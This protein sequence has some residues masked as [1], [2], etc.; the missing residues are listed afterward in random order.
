MMLP[1]SV[2]RILIPI[3]AF[4]LPCSA[5]SPNSAVN[6]APDSILAVR[7]F[8]SNEYSLGKPIQVTLTIQS[9]SDQD[10]N[11]TIAENL[12]PK[13]TASQ[14]NHGGL[15][16][17]ETL[18]W[19]LS[20]KIGSLVLSY[21]VQPPA[22]TTDAA[23]FH[24]FCGGVPITGSQFLSPTILKIQTQPNG[25]W[26]YWTTADGLRETCGLCQ[27]GHDGKIWIRHGSVN[28]ISCLD[29][30]AVSKIPSPGIWRTLF[31]SQ[32][33]QLWSFDS[34]GLKLF[35]EGKWIA[36]PLDG[37][38]STQVKILSVEKDRV[39]LC[40]PDRLAEFDAI[41]NQ[42]YTIR[43]AAE[44]KLLR[45]ANIFTAK[46]G[47][48]LIAGRQGMARW[49]LKNRRSSLEASWTDY[50]FPPEYE[51]SN[52][53]FLVE[54]ENG[55]IYGSA[56]SAHFNKRVL[57]QFD[58]TAWRIKFVADR[59]IFAGWPGR[60]NG[61]WLWKSDEYYPFLDYLTFQPNEIHETNIQLPSLTSIQLPILE[62]GSP[63]T[64][65]S[66]HSF[67][68]S[69]SPGIARFALAA[70][71]TPETIANL[72]E[73]I[74]A[75][76]VDAQGRLWFTT[77]N[78]LLRLQNQE[79]KIYPLPDGFSAYQWEP[80]GVAYLKNGQ[81]AIRNTNS[82]LLLFDPET[83][84]FRVVN[85][86]QGK[87]ISLIFPRKDGSI[88]IQAEDKTST[89]Q[90]FVYSLEIY[91]GDSFRPFAD[92][93]DRWNL[94]QLRYIYE[95]QD[96]AI[97]LGGMAD[98]KIGVY[99]NGTYKTMGG[100]Y[101]GDSVMCIFPY[102]E[103]KLWFSDRNGIYEYDGEKWSVIR[104]GLDGVPSMIRSRDGSIWI[105]TWNG[106]YRYEHNSWIQNSELE[107]LSSFCIFKV[108]EDSQGRLWAATSRGLNLYHPEA[109]PDPP[110]VLIDP[111]V[112]ADEIA[113]GAVAKFVFSGIDKW[114]YTPQNRLLYSHR[115]DNGPW[116]PFAEDAVANY[117][118]LS[119]GAHHF[120][121]KAMDRNWNESASP[122]LF[123]FEVLRRWYQ[124]PIFL[125]LLFTGSVI[126]LSAVGYAISRHINLE[127]LVTKRTADLL[128]A[129][130]KLLSYQQQLQS[131]AS[132]MSLIEE[133]DRRQI[134]EELH[135]RI[136]HGLAAC[137]MQI[138]TIK[139]DS[140]DP[141][142]VRIF[143][144]TL[145]LLE[146]TILDARSLTFEISPPVLYE[147]GLEPALEWL[148]EE[149]EKH[150]GM[151]IEL[152]D[153]GLPKTV[154]EDARGVLFRSVRELLF[155]VLKHSG[156][157]CAKVA[158]Q[159][160]PE[161]VSLCV[162][163]HGTGFNFSELHSSAL[164]RHSFGLFSIRE[165]IEY[166]GGSF[167]CDSARGKGTR[168]VLTMPCSQEISSRRS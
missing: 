151:K 23:F 83:E 136:G 74:A 122:A 15:L 18:I 64:Y 98:E 156:A 13:W 21:T 9:P 119:P 75:M 27:V 121:V 167:E 118:H 109:D 155:N 40:F 49:M 52:L 123:Q 135:D 153:D 162:E 131:F 41:H 147:L 163:D 65:E 133:R 130:K 39:F 129:Q 16:Q 124:E 2:L 148:I 62:S 17:K 115:I 87:K 140:L 78:K 94:E 166:L 127:Q 1:I 38:D 95:D 42:T 106:I 149:M 34:S 154:S 32:E 59:N 84:Q 11:L 76:C 145:A 142:S 54:D 66:N 85:H 60:D 146:Q 168:I 120:E 138:E 164:H 28:Q 117:S 111:N 33:N 73:H 71:R 110:K 114:K 72:N 69:L 99:R 30:Y 100:E 93:G 81:L 10:R 104:T 102:G 58:N 37:F 107:G 45:F 86:P 137:Q 132:E 159:S 36:Y 20:G 61:F 4:I 126:T 160:K 5:Q 46:D 77:F 19:S 144:Q 158:I 82:V 68:I 88:W 31:E 101:P 29:G 48:V 150:Y 3:L 6:A 139:R 70:W 7:S 141:Q 35:L 80:N 63:V 8:S 92:L 90:R 125:L 47:D 67:W 97:W 24:G 112:N 161:C 25:H 12:P 22:E 108:F 57:M 55:Q 53:D 116:S 89:R 26:R 14:I 91:D 96:G 50:P 113:P 143:D 103:R 56:Q 134:A 79:W 165:R 105:A 152:E 44:T 51:V 43:S 128:N 157:L